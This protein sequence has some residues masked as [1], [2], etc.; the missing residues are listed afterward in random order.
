MNL[1]DLKKEYNYWLKRN[2]NAEIFFTSKNMEECLKYINLF[3]EITIKLS[4][5]RDRLEKAL[6]RKLTKQEI[7]NGF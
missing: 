1:E 5:L 2:E 3:N 6:Q 4:S 7:L